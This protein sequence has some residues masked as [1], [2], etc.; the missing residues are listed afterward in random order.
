MHT[1]PAAFHL[2]WALTTARA[3]ASSMMSFAL[4]WTATGIGPGT[5]ALVSTLS[6]QVVLLLIGGVVGD[7][8]GPR[9]VLVLTI[10]VQT[11][12]MVVLAVASARTVGALLLVVAATALSVIVA[13]EQ[14][15]ASVLPR[16][17]IRDDDQLPQALARITTSTQIARIGGVAISGVLVAHF[18]LVVPFV[19]VAT[20]ALGS[21]LAVL[22]IRP[23]REPVGA[24]RVDVLGAFRA[25]K[26]LRL[27]PMLIAVALVAGAV[28]PVVGVVFPS[29][30]RARGWGASTTGLLEVAWVIGSLAVSTVVSLRGT[31]PRIRIPL[32]GGPIL[33][34]L[35]LVSLAVPTSPVTSIVSAAMVGTGTALFT[36]HI[37]PLLLRSVPLETMTRF[38]SLLTLVQILPP[39]LLNSPFAVAGR[40]AL[41]LTAGMALAAALV[42]S[43]ATPR[44]PAP[45]TSPDQ[46]S[47]GSA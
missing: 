14:P 5:V 17:L 16:L 29:L 38:Q 43:A 18:S 4:I 42:V 9:R 40:G 10:S 39:A 25:V 3:V 1:L 26:E 44:E 46:R 36:S 27:W 2:W 21:L 24:R 45:P 32:V 6:A 47:A 37:A 19:L 34:T 33:A 7:R 20:T 31:L 12:L 23:Q 30:G 11:L 8:L 41:L 35:S 28:L 22:V 13:F 15:A